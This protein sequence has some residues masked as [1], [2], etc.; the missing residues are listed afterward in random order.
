MASSLPSESA[1]PKAVKDFGLGAYDGQSDASGSHGEDSE[2]REP[3]GKSLPD[4][5]PPDVQCPG[6]L[7]SYPDSPDARLGSWHR[8]IFAAAN[9]PGEADRPTSHAH[10]DMSTLDSSVPSVAKTSLPSDSGN[11]SARSD[12]FDRTVAGVED[13][14]ATEDSG[15]YVSQEKSGSSELPGVVKNDEHMDNGLQSAGNWQSGFVLQDAADPHASDFAENTDY[16]RDDPQDGG[17]ILASKGSPMNR[18]STNISLVSGL[19]ADFLKEFGKKGLTKRHV[20]SF[21]QSRGEPQFLSSDVIR[22]L[23]LS[24]EI[25]VK[26]VLDEFPVSKKASSPSLASL[27]DRIIGLEADSIEI[28]SVSSGFRRC[29]ADLARVMADL[30]RIGYPNG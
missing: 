21:L 7:L 18:V 2:A 10:P 8:N 14:W 1:L 20:L 15:A 6:R 11:P 22:C 24:H 26:D 12:Y 17:R 28:P 19:T 30:E 16:D 25:Y 4:P 29:A 3:S 13:A 9:V 23:K 27:R 5:G